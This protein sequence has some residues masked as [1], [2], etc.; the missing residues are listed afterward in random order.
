MKRR[1]SC[2]P[3]PSPPPTGS[4]SLFQ[5]RLCKPL[6]ELLTPAP[7]TTHLTCFLEDRPYCGAWRLA[8]AAARGL[9]SQTAVSLNVTNG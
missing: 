6:Y 3:Y 5:I 7:R 1:Q 2:A 4:L 8:R 9:C